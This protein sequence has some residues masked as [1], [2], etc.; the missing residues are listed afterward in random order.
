MMSDSLTPG[1]QIAMSALFDEYINTL[2]PVLAMAESLTLSFP[3]PIL[4]EIRAVNDH[5][6]RCFIAERTESEHLDELN[7]AKRHL[8]RATLDCYKILLIEYDSRVRSFFDSYKDVCIAVVNDGKF[9]PR[10]TEL[11]DTAKNWRIGQNGC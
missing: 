8:T 4:N 3:G 10:L 6:S 5:V 9:L 7:K 11:Y 2:K 1:V